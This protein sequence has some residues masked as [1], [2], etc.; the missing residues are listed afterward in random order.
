MDKLAE[1]LRSARLEKGLS[2][3]DIANRT[4]VRERYVD[5]LERGQYDVLPAVYIKSF[6]RTVAGA[7]SVPV[8]E[9]NRLMDEVFDAEDSS[10][11]R[12]PSKATAPA[13]IPTQR[14]TL[15]IPK[16]PSLRSIPWPPSKK[17]LIIA[18]LAILAVC[19]LAWAAT[20]SRRNEGAAGADTTAIGYTQ[21]DSMILTALATDTAWLNITMDG[22]RNQQLVTRP[23]EEY[24]FS[25]SKQFLLS[26]GNAAAITLFR[27]GKQLPPLGKAEQ[28]VRKV[29]ITRSDVISSAVPPKPPS[30]APPRPAP[31]PVQSRPATP[32]AAAPQRAPVRQATVRATT[33]P[34]TQR[35]PLRAPARTAAQTRAAAAARSRAQQRRP[36]VRPAPTRRPA[37]VSRQLITPAPRR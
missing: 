25:A 23:G 35:I 20:S 37:P 24:R 15:P 9:V 32:A 6:V 27:D 14:F 2:I 8:S 31:P 16:L 28:I 5:A 11:D 10:N 36:V 18:S 17:V 1:R 26:V 3:R 22:Q 7:V 12:L 13:A 19:V 4:R 21:A 33:R 29:E 34:A 30:V